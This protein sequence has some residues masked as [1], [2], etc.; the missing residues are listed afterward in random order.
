MTVL[1]QKKIPEWSERRINQ[2][3]HPSRFLPFLPTCLHIHC[4]YLLPF[5]YPSAMFSLAWHWGTGS[6]T[7]SQQ[8]FVSLGGC[9]RMS[10]NLIWNPWNWQLST[11]TVGSQTSMKSVLSTLS[12]IK[13]DG[14]YECTINL[15]SAWEHFT[16][17]SSGWLFSMEEKSCC[18]IKCTQIPLSCYSNNNILPVYIHIILCNLSLIHSV[19]RK[20]KIKL[21]KGWHDYMSREH[22]NKRHE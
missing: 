15:S 8:S 21:T 1:P 3:V 10:V 7:S 19:Q 13:M 18:A 20:D 12:F 5:L 9:S 2:S 16:F 17:P 14:L 4:V 22:T 11:N 6:V